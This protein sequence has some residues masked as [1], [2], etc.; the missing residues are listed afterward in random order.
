MM[1]I[2]QKVLYI[3]IF[4]L[5][6]F[7]GV[8]GATIALQEN[9]SFK[10]SPITQLSSQ[11]PQTADITLPSAPSSLLSAVS[12]TADSQP[13][14]PSPTPKPTF[15]ELNEKYGPCVVLPTLMYHHVEDEAIAKAA[16]HQSLTVAPNYFQEQ[17][18]YLQDKHYTVITMQDLID[19]FD[20]Q[21]PLP[22]KPVLITFDDGYADFYNTAWPILQ[23]LNFHATM[24]VPTGL[25][26]NPDYMT[27][28]NIESLAESGK[29]LLSN[30]TWSHKNM[31][32]NGTI[33]AKEITTAAEQLAQH[34][35]DSPKVFAYPYGLVS[36]QAQKILQDTGYKLAFTTVHGST[37]CKQQRLTL[38][39]IRIGNASLKAYGL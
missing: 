29:I 10:P 27:W 35:L 21:K 8:T 23:P 32:S 18:Q 33:D 12:A 1:K 13:A 16:N 6:L 34:H 3:G 7:L 38:P 37:L 31:Q 2:K 11:T 25:L 15:A 30:H 26:E 14:S 19:F 17:M 5:F 4:L 24:F 22:S 39:R 28:A 20:Q 9:L 36:D